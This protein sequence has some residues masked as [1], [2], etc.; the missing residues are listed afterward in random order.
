MIWSLSK[1]ATLHMSFGN[2][3]D[4][5]SNTVNYGLPGNAQQ[6]HSEHITHCYIL[7]ARPQSFSQEKQLGETSEIGNAYISDFL[8]EFISENNLFESSAS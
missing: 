2:T 8:F 4:L 6:N 1:A 3:L 5:N 7:Q